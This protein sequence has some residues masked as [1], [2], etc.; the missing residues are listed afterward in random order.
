MRLRPLRKPVSLP[1]VQQ[2]RG[3]ALTRFADEVLLAAAR[4]VSE[5]VVEEP[6]PGADATYSGSTLVTIPLDR[7][8]LVGVVDQGGSELL[9]DAARRSISLHVRLGRLARVEAERRSSPRLPRDVDIEMEFAIDGRDL[10]VDI[11]VECT[12]AEP[13]TDVEGAGEEEP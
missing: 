3:I 12:L 8:D 5:G 7:S 6:T 1:V 9:L 10:L 11:N 13:L 2:L 4:V